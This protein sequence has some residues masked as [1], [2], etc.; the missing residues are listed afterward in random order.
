MVD[1]I[2]MERA[3]SCEPGSQRALLI[4]FLSY[5]FIYFSVLGIEL[6]ALHMLLN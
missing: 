3:I 4:F 6:R 5:I 1:V 2:I